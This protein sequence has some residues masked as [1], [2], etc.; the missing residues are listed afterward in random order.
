MHAVNHMG[1]SRRREVYDFALHGDLQWPEGAREGPWASQ[2][3]FT[4]LGQC[5][6]FVTAVVSGIFSSARDPILWCIRFTKRSGDRGPYVA[7][8][9]A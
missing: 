2:T 3:I 1:M 4:I 7:P 5:G 8:R 6:L 9:M